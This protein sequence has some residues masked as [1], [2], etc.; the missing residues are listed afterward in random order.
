MNQIPAPD[1]E[2]AFRVSPKF[3]RET[4]RVLLILMIVV[5]VFG[6]LALMSVVNAPLL[7]SAGLV[8]ALVLLMLVFTVL[9]LRRSTNSTSPKH[10]VKGHTSAKHR[11]KIVEQREQLGARTLV[12]DLALLAQLHSNGQLTDAEFS[13]LKSKLMGS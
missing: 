10:F 4:L 11:V 3:L 7:N 1:T 6:G 9:F 2:I 5:A 13:S 12:Q 8:F